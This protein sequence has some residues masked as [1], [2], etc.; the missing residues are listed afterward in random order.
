MTRAAVG[1]RV[2]SGWAA[3]V[4][5]SGT[6]RSPEIVDRRRVELCEASIRGSKQ[7]YHAAEALPPRDAEALIGRCRAST[8]SLA[9]RGMEEI[10]RAHPIAACGVL[11][12]S[13]RPLPD[14]AGILASHALIHTAE[15]EFFRNA[16]A[17][18]A[19]ELKLPV[20]AVKE[21][22]LL[23]VCGAELGLSPAALAERLAAWGRAVGPP[24]RQDEK[25]AA[26]AAWLVLSH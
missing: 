1:F 20:R 12:A 8:A 23:Q 9:R 4:T 10:R 15:G 19:R 11:M 22:E 25:F 16:I 6:Q 7:P 24:W 13:G 21:R 2:H 5:L 3:A 26:L 18:T 17:E 14:L